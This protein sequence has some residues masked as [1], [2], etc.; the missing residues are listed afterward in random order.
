[1]KCQ[2]N[3]MTTRQTGHNAPAGRVVLLPVA[4]LLPLAGNRRGYCMRS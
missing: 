3:R 2:V 1:M 4:L